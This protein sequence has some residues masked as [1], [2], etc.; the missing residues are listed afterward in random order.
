MQKLTSSMRLKVNRDTFVFPDPAKGVYLRNN[1]KS[2]KMDG[3]T[4]DRWLEQLLPA[5][6]GTRTLEAVTK[7]LPDAFKEQAYKIAQVLYDNGFVCDTSQ[8]L[9]HQ[10][11][12][13]ILTKYASQIEYIDQVRDSGGY[14]FQR[15]RQ[16]NIAVVGSGTLLPSLI[17]SLLQSGQP[18]F[19]IL[20]SESNQELQ[21]RLDEMINLAEKSEPETNV[22]LLHTVSND[23]QETLQPFDYI[24][25]ASND[26]DT[27]Q[28]RSLLSFCQEKRKHFLPITIIKDLAFAGPY[29]SADSETCW[30]SAFRRLHL[31]S[32]EQNNAVSK[33]AV[34]LLANVAV[35]ELFKEITGIH[36]NQKE[37]PLYVLN[38]ETLEG[39]WHP[40]LPHPLIKGSVKA[41]SVK[42]PMK[43]LKNK[44]VQEKDLHALFYQITSQTNGILHLWEEADSLQLPLSQCKVQAANPRSEGPASCYPEMIGSGLTHEEAR[45]EAGLIGL[46]TYVA[47]YD[48]FEM[49]PASW[50]VGIG[51]T[52][53]E[54]MCR[55][56]Q[57]LVHKEFMK[58]AKNN[59]LTSKIENSTVHDQH[60]QF[61]LQTLSNPQLSCGREVLGFPVIWVEYNHKWYGGIGLNDVTALRRALKTAVMDAQNKGTSHSPY[62][63]VVSS[64]K[65]EKGA[66]QKT[67]AP[68]FDEKSLDD[69]L[70]SAFHCLKKN[71][72]QAYVYELH[73]E[74]FLSEN[75]SGIYGIAF[76]GEVL[77]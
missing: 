28:L 5:F 8:D 45:L 24:L 7:G 32:N 34:A 22:T 19:S 68:S 33:T 11:S 57:N 13:H 18:S 23:W 29:V 4:I 38:V 49:P 62:G 9:P 15:Y 66:Q 48:F 44:T 65:S 77:S 10:L 75:S 74:P 1:E 64:I 27:N 20:L 61:F 2:L 46:E 55:A 51:K 73:A 21:T 71:Q 14:R 47:G 3:S 42:D 63:V 60:S 37:K 72:K 70:R 30:E 39:S 58:Q 53:T 41:T 16:A 67:P 36:E 56:L 54:G 17:H 31:T 59:V 12:E 43:F 76:N 40:F 52:P 26:S 25:Y 35:F 50:G 69:T 6:D